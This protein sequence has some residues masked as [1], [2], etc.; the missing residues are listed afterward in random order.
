MNFVFEDK[1]NGRNLLT[2]NQNNQT[3]WARFCIAPFFNLIRCLSSLSDTYKDMSMMFSTDEIPEKYILSTGVHNDPKNWGGGELSGHE[4]YPSIFEFLSN[5]YL[6]DIRNKKAILLID[7]SL[8]GFHDDWIFEFLHHECSRFEINPEQVVYVTGNLNVSK[9]YEKWLIE[10]P[11]T[12]KINPFEY[13]HFQTDVYLFTRNLPKDNTTHPPTFEEQLNYKKQNIENI[14]LFSYLNKKPRIHR[15]NFYKLLY[16]NNLL[17]DGLVSMEDFGA[18][19]MDFGGNNDDNNTFCGYSFSKEFV[20]QIKQTLPARIYGRSNKEEGIEYVTRFHPEVA[21]DSWVQV[22]SETYFYEREDTLFISE[23]TFKV[24]ASSQPFI[25]LGSKGSLKG[26]KELGYKTFD[27]W[28]DESYDELEDC[29]RMDAIIKVLKDI[30]SIEDKASWF[31]EM[32]E[33]LEHN[34]NLLEKNTLEN[35]PRVFNEVSNLYNSL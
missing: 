3:G 23:K 14:K 32:K 5:Q 25:I 7:N 33:V 6:Q 27:K 34:K 28:F 16:F 17:K 20:D 26:L 10:N 18:H 22:I 31:S 21:L 4:N 13:P 29:D 30:N 8:E 15:V 12:R 35:P 1:E 9:S 19:G 2:G 11:Q 24:I